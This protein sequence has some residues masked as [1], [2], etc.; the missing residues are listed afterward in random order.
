M[1]LGWK[2]TGQRRPPWAEEP[3]PGRVSVWDFPR[4]PRLETVDRPVR[5]EHAGVVIADTRGAL[6][7]VETAGAPVYYIPPGDVRTDLLES[8]PGSSLCEWKGRAVYHDLALPPGLTGGRAIRVPR[9]AW[10][11][12]DPSRGWE[13]IRGHVAFYASRLDCCRVGDDLVRPQPGGFYGGWVTPDLAGP[14]K[15]APG[16]HHW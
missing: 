14:I 1:A 12:P 8:V 13:A 7:V 11:Y 10:S 5:V 16:T 2:W 6:R 4:P 3:G 15:G 9:A